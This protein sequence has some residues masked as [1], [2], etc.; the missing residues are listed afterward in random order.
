MKSQSIQ[1]MQ[2]KV[3][4]AHLAS[5]AAPMV[6]DPQGGVL[7]VQ[8]FDRAQ[9]INLAPFILVADGA[10]VGLCN[11]GAAVKDAMFHIVN[12]LMSLHPPENKRKYTFVQC[13]AY[14]HFDYVMREF[15]DAGKLLSIRLVPIRSVDGSPARSVDALRSLLPATAIPA[16][17]ALE[18]RFGAK[19]KK[20]LNRV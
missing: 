14:G 6:D 20:A 17:E 10:G 9:A 3:F 11:R 2:S 19:F 18:R 13:D 1:S 12:S 16:I 5:V 4:R 8:C 15:D 7:I